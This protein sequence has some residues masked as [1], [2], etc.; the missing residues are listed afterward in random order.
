MIGPDQQFG[1]EQNSISQARVTAEKG[2]W[3][4]GGAGGGAEVWGA[5]DGAGGDGVGVGGKSG[6]G[7]QGLGCG[8]EGGKEGGAGGGRADVQKFRSS[9]A[10]SSWETIRAEAEADARLMASKSAR[11]MTDSGVCRGE[12]GRGR[13]EILED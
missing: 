13:V 6:E 1:D 9:Q 12:G 8:K 5:G 7:R 2:G 3:E 11:P 10:P 4:G